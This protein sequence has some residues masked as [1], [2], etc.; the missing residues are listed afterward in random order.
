MMANRI[1]FHFLDVAIMHLGA[2]PVSI[3]NTLR[4]SEIAYILQNSGARI[5]FAE[6][7]HVAALR[8][9]DTTHRRLDQIVVIDGAAEGAVGLGDVLVEDATFDIVTAAEQV[10]PE[11]LATISYT[12][13]TTGAPKG[14][15]LSHRSILRSIE[16]I[17]EA[18]GTREGA[19]M[20]SFLPMAHVAERM[21]S[22]WRGMVHGFTITPCPHPSQ[23]GPYLID[24]QPDYVFSPPRLF[25]KLRAAIEVGFEADTDPNRRAATAEALRVG[26]D[27]VGREQ[28]GQEVPEDL[29]R[30][31][32][33]LQQQV[34]APALAR[35][36][37][38]AVDVALT[39]SAPVPPEL[40]RHFLVLG[41]P[42]YEG[43]GMSEVTAFGVF[44]RPGDTRVGTVGYPLRGAQIR[45]AD[46][47]ELLF[48]SG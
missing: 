23:A 26:A 6:A 46:D 9:A 21:F 35:V 36:G 37:L 17:H 22:H 5:A 11:D 43:W 45:L 39:G 33:Q 14:V 47:G 3:Y 18:F 16:A 32:E 15:E 13:G 42:I 30:R 28:T 31:Y 34:L 40:V 41:L 20:V 1:E 44:N 19:R 4:P 27:K 38:D 29:Q 24:V 7:I 2:V 12:S 48:R 10:R 8:E 25:E